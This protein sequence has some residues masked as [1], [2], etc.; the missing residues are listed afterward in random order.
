MN[1]SVSVVD[2]IAHHLKEAAVLRRIAHVYA[3]AGAGDRDA[4]GHRP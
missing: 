4:G 1:I 3:A 2:R